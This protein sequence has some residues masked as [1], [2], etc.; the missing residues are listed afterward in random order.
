[1]IVEIVSEYISKKC[2]FFRL[3]MH[4]YG[5][6]GTRLNVSCLHGFYIRFTLRTRVLSLFWTCCQ[7]IHINEYIFLFVDV[8]RGDRVWKGGRVISLPE[9]P[10]WL[11]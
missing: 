6:S 9:K 4:Q 1:M 7:F 10:L 5:R 3:K 2:D 8:H 11:H